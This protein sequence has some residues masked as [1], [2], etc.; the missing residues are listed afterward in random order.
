MDGVVAVGVVRV[1]PLVHLHVVHGLLVGGR[2]HEVEC[3]GVR[4]EW[5]ELVGGC[6][7]DGVGLELA[8]VLELLL[9]VGP[10]AVW[11]VYLVHVLVALVGSVLLRREVGQSG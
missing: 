8:Q 4:V 5:R 11:S 2:V 1:L 10:R 3:V 6:L 9:H 7:D